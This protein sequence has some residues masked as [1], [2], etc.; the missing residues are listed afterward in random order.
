MNLEENK[1]IEE[2][3]NGGSFHPILIKDEPIKELKGY[4]WAALRYAAADYLK[5]NEDALG[6]YDTLLDTFDQSAAIEDNKLYIGDFEGYA[7]GNEDQQYILKAF[8]F[9]V[10]GRLLALIEEQNEEGEEVSLEW[11]LMD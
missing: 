8:A 11:Y 7:F 9:S 2:L 6:L 5:T 10:A 4:D 1:Q 3:S